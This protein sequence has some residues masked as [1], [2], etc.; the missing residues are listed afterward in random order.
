[1]TNKYIPKNLCPKCSKITWDYD[2]SK[3]I[4]NCP[5]CQAKGLTTPIKKKLHGI[6]GAEI[7][8]DNK[9]MYVLSFPEY[10]ERGIYPDWNTLSKEMDKLAKNE[11]KK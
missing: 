10:K 1:M 5:F 3:D 11:D 2:E 4:I 7:S 6:V 8:K 9:G